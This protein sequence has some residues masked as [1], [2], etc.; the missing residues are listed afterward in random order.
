MADG[1]SLYFDYVGKDFLP[2]PYGPVVFGDGVLAARK[3]ALE[4]FALL[5][6][7]LYTLLA[8]NMQVTRN[9]CSKSAGD[10]RFRSLLAHR[11]QG[12]HL[13]IRFT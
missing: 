4:L 3:T 1:F 13:L 5:R 12:G 11:Q 7:L 9:F 2:T 6:T 8:G 10:G